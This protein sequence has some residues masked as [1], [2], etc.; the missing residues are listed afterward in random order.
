[1]VQEHGVMLRHYAALQARCTAQVDAL[2]AEVEALRA[3][4]TQLRAQV[5]MRDSALI[6]E[7]EDRLV[8]LSAIAN[9]AAVTAVRRCVDPAATMEVAA[10][11]PPPPDAYL[12]ELGQHATNL[13][14]CQTGCISHGGYWREHDQCKRLGSTCLLEDP[15]GFVPTETAKAS[16][17]WVM[18]A[19][20]VPAK[21]LP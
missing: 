14:I 4:V 8:H 21:E 7:R 2:R 1:M 13:V 5:I 15:Q 9:R 20:S 3:Q 12:Q 11:P 16:H 18:T 17:A 19:A 6:W 10:V